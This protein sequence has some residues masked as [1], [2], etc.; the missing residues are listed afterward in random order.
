MTE[1]PSFRQI[2]GDLR[3]ENIKNE[4]RGDWAIAFLYRIPSLVF[5][6]GFVRMGLGPM[7]VS[8]LGLVISL[9]IPPLALWLPFGLAI[10]A[11]CIC[12]VLFQILDCSDGTIARVSGRTSILGADLDYFF[13]MTHYL[14]LYPAI[15]IL[16][17][18]G[19]DTG[20][21]WTV[22]AVVAVAIRFLA[23]LI[24][25]QIALRKGPGE[26]KPL[27]FADLPIS[28]LAGLSGLIAFGA[29]AGPYL[30]FVV[31][32]L[33]IYSVLDVIDASLPLRNP[34]FRNDS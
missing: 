22:I 17:D 34:P 5:S 13:G 33:L 9:F 28:F 11:V 2:V 26:P 18:R 31:I 7:A 3:S 1:T 20:L 25:D 6:W 24:R 27:K 14:C 23:R 29:L 15:G 10:W 16:A 8:T 32:A 21:F 19:L 4:R 12:G 30:G